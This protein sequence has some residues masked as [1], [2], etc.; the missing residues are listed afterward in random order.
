MKIDAGMVNTILF[1]ITSVDFYIPNL[2]MLIQSSLLKYVKKIRFY[3]HIKVGK[4]FII[5]FFS[6]K[7]PVVPNNKSKKSFLTHEQNALKINGEDLF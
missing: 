1:S 2:I 3:L 6:I 7:V 5:F 4:V